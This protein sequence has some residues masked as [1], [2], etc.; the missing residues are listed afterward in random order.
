MYVDKRLTSIKAVQTLSRLNLAHPKKHDTFVLDFFNDHKTIEGSFSPFYRTTIL[1]NETAPNKLNALKSDLD[2]AH[3]YTDDEVDNFVAQYLNG[4]D[5]GPLDPLLD[6]CVHRYMDELDE[7]VQIKFKG[8]AKSFVRT[9]AFW[10]S[11]LPYSLATWEK[12][13]IFLNFLIPKLPAPPGRRFG[14]WPFGNHRHGQL[15]R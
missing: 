5:R 4:A 10:A 2:G 15:P 7:D 13:S 14:P 8:S 3:I 1:S 9:Y 11:I 6:I 12:L